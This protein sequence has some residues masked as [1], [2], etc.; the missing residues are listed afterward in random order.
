[1]SSVRK[2]TYEWLLAAFDKEIQTAATAY[3][4]GSDTLE[5]FRS[6]Q[7]RLQTWKAA[8]ELIIAKFKEGDGSDKTD[9]T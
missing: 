3:E 2:S 4:R 7:A 5:G 9:S 1:M 8:R 6:L